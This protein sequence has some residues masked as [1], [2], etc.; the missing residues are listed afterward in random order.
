MRSHVIVLAN[1]FPIPQIAYR[2]VVH[3][4]IQKQNKEHAPPVRAVHKVH[5]DVAVV[6]QIPDTEE[7]TEWDKHDKM[8]PI[9]VD[10][11]KNNPKWKISLQTHKYLGIP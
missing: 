8:I 5:K 4:D 11:V 9:M 7:W 1:C 10:Y 3:F 2:D 6:G